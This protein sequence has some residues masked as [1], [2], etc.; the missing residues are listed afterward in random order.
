MFIFFLDGDFIISTDAGHW[1]SQPVDV[2]T[3]GAGGVYR[4]RSIATVVRRRFAFDDGCDCSWLRIK[5]LPVL[6][7]SATRNKSPAAGVADP[8]VQSVVAINRSVVELFTT[9]H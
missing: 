1:N 3:C 4:I 8:A 7:K 9:D 5:F 6:F 2:N